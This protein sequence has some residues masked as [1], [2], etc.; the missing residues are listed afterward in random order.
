MKNDISSTRR[1]VDPQMAI[2]LYGQSGSNLTLRH[3]IRWF[4]RM[5]SMSLPKGNRL[6]ARHSMQ[7]VGA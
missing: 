3:S 6:R 7:S 4:I 2:I 5:D 1:R